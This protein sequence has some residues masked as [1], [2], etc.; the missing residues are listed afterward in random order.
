MLPVRT[1]AKAATLLTNP[2]TKPMGYLC[3][4]TVNAEFVLTGLSNTD[5]NARNHEIGVC[6]PQFT[7]E[8][9]S[10]CK[11]TLRPKYSSNAFISLLQVGEPEPGRP[12]VPRATDSVTAINDAVTNK[13]GY[14][15]LEPQRCPASYTATAKGGKLLASGAACNALFCLRCKGVT[16]RS[17]LSN[18]SF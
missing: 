1:T 16:A 9:T 12:I 7:L 8:L 10:T 6:M 2:H 13:L 17:I 3:L 18:T 4:H 11:L 15:Y 14:Y 5:G